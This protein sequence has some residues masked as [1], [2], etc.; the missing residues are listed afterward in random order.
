LQCLTEI[1]SLEAVDSQQYGDIILNIYTIVYKEMAR[2][3]P[4]STD[5]ACL[6]NEPSTSGDDQHFIESLA[7]FITTALSKYRVLIESMEGGQSSV[8]QSLVYLLEI[9]RVPEREIWK[10]CLEYWGKLVK[11]VYSHKQVNKANMHYILD[12]RHSSRFESRSIDTLS[13]YIKATQLPHD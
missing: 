10:I 2:I 11:L 5:I 4:K 8:H 9:S 7:I 3:I 6:Y 12:I 13:R 1:I